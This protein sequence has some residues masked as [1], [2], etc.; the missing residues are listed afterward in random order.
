V[1]QLVP[2]TLPTHDRRAEHYWD[3]LE[4]ELDD[5]LL[6]EFNLEAEDGSPAE[7]GAALHS[8]PCTPAQIIPRSCACGHYCPLYM[9]AQIART[10]VDMYRECVAG[11]YARVLQMRAAASNRPSGAAQ[12]RRLVVRCCLYWTWVSRYQ[13]DC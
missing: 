1:P 6:Q 13:A 4:E 9:R 2:N 8:A 3:D 10:L 11:N 12:S 5:A 7:V